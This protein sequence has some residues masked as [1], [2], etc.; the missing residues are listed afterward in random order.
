LIR[1]L[2]GR[3]LP[4]ELG[5]LIMRRALDSDAGPMIRYR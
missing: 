1:F 2:S 3:G 4:S 5:Q